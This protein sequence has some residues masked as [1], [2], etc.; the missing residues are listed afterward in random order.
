MRFTR[1]LVSV[2]AA[3]CISV[4]VSAA[5]VWEPTDGDI[6]TFDLAFGITGL[7][8]GI[9]DDDNMG[10]EPELG[11]LPLQIFDRVTFQQAGSDWNLVNTSGDLFTLTGS[12]RFLIAANDGSGWTAEA[13]Y[14]PVGDWSNSQLLYFDSPSLLLAVDVRP[15]PLPGALLL[16]AT[17]LAGMATIARRKGVQVE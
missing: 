10:L 7:S 5:T 15:V 8:Y 3:A 4:S 6:N 13:G 17:G 9:F 12:N 2:M 11:Y 16:M 14:I 1:K